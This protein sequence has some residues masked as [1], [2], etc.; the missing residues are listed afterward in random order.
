MSENLIAVL[1]QDVGQAACEQAAYRLL[2][3]L[4]CALVGARE[5]QGLAVIRYAK[6]LPEGN[7]ACIGGGKREAS[8][9]AFVNGALGNILE[10][11]DLHR[12]AIVHPGDTVIPAVLAVAQRELSTSGE[13]LRAIVRG[14]EAAIR[15]GEAAG[16][17]H[18]RYWYSTATCG[19][20][21]AAV[22]AGSLMSLD[23]D[24][25]SDAVGLAGM[26]SSGLW[27]C[28]LEKGFA[29]QLASARAAQSGVLA[30]DLAKCGFP[31]PRQIIDG[32]LGLL[33]ATST[34]S[35][36][37]A[38]TKTGS[39][40][41]KVGEVSEKPWPGCRH[42]HPVIEA[43]LRYRVKL[44]LD[45]I[46]HVEVYTYK[47]AVDFCDDAMPDTPHRARFSL[48][49]AFAIAFIKGEPELSDY[50]GEVLADTTIDTLRS[51]VA[52]FESPDLSAEFPHRYGCRL[53]VY[54]EDGECMRESILSAKGD[55][56]NPV[57]ASA[58][59]RKFRSLAAHAGLTDEF[60]HDLEQTIL[61]LPSE[62]SCSSKLFDGL[63]ALID[64]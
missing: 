20:F 10:M 63:E 13:L 46:S 3:W 47:S 1:E 19:V 15:V 59:R 18:Y 32:R 57:D 54:T 5:E 30:A 24:K 40:C 33:A 43:A 6:T 7:V 53:I 9:S 28:R 21:G 8:T 27:Q 52:V 26:Q 23:R 62:H 16:T 14:Y 22:A 4:G 25:L 61:G 12:M 35:R 36:V 37:E 11:D 64:L 51:K 34:N 38:L 29:K 55:P 41:W 42:T 50:V 48:Q 17:E 45:K 31:A 58:S 44:S 39:E 49:H 56:E 60:A 2:D